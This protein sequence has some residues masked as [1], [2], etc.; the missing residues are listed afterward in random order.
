MGVPPS[1]LFRLYY[2]AVAAA[3]WVALPLYL[4]GVTTSVA[5]LV[6]G[7]AARAEGR[8]TPP[9][10]SQIISMSLGMVGL[11]ATI[12]VASFYSTVPSIEPIP[13]GL[14]GLAVV[15][16][17]LLVLGG[18]RLIA[19]WNRAH[20]LHELL[21]LDWFYRAVWQG[22]N[23]MLGVVRVTADVVEGSGSVLWSALI[24][25]LVL[26]VASGR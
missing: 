20:T 24:L 17:S 12:L 8:V 3:P 11:M 16:G 18:R 9:H 14:W 25:L 19:V 10:P 5:A 7:S 4:V 6:V 22:A 23:N 13:F 21:D 1:P 26:M 2:G 15:G